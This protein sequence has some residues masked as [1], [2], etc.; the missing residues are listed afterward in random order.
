[1]FGV[2]EQVFVVVVGCLG[3]LPIM[4]DRRLRTYVHCGGGHQSTT[5]TVSARFTS[6][7]SVRADASGV[8]T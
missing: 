4:A 2:I 8:Q 1:M 5:T 6:R 7:V 3:R